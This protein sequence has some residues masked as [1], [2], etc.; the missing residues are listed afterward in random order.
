MQ[1]PVV[2]I[3][4]TLGSIYENLI[5]RSVPCISTYRST[6]QNTQSDCLKC[7]IIESNNKLIYFFPLSAICVHHCSLSTY[8]TNK[9]NKC[10]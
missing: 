6:S 10:C 9:D 5:G 8:F 1:E 2:K 4:A 7:L 3:P